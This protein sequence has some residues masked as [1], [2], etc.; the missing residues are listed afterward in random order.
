MNGHSKSSFLS[1]NLE[2]SLR[3]SIGD[4]WFILLI[5]SVLP[6]AQ[7][8]NSAPSTALSPLTSR[9]HDLT[10]RRADSAIVEKCLETTGNIDEY[11]NTFD[12]NQEQR[13]G[14]RS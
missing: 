14:S 13:V 3:K 9:E 8:S 5:D 1:G 11:S 10:T 6:R 2:D 4:E 7:K 12:G